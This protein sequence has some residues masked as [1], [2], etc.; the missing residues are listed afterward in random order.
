LISNM[1]KAVYMM[2]S[3]AH[4]VSSCLTYLPLAENTFRQDKC[5]S[6]FCFFGETP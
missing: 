5:F 1:P 2:Q 3:G 4:V 6:A